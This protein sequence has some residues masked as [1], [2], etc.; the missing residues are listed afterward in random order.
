MRY[1]LL[2]ASRHLFA[3]RKNR[4]LIVITAISI[5]GVAVGVAALIATLAVMNGFRHEFKNRIVS[6][7]PHIFVEKQYGI[8]DAEDLLVKIDSIKGIKGSYPY[9]WGQSVIRIGQRNRGV[10]IRSLDPENKIDLNKV[11]PYMLIGEAG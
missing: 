5:L 3:G 6:S 1:E 7:G 2:I 4:L 10:A 9:V 8:E 11:K